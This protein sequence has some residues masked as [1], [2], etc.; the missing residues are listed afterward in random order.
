MN[1]KI[2][3]R[4]MFQQA[5]RQH[6]GAGSAVKK[7]YDFLTKKPIAQLKK[8]NEWDKGLSPLP[9]GSIP[10]TK[11]PRRFPMN[12]IIPNRKSLKGAYVGGAGLCNIF[13]FM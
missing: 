12:A 9:D 13:L 8:F 10:I 4:P 2:L 6:Y 5:Q 11:K 1:K 7:T 3:Q